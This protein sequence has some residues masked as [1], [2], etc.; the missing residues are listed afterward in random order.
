M[1]NAL[2]NIATDV[3]A[4]ATPVS[5]ANRSFT[6]ILAN[7][8][9]QKHGIYQ[10]VLVVNQGFS[11]CLQQRKLAFHQGKKRIFCSASKSCLI[12]IKDFL[13]HVMIPAEVC[14]EGIKQKFSVQN[15]S[16]SRLFCIA[17][18][19]NF[20]YCFDTSEYKPKKVEFIC[21]VFPDIFYSAKFSYCKNITYVN[22]I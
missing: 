10:L 21:L 22:Y 12:D 17:I 8:R 9:C 18:I 15:I 16:K 14:L 6:V 2:S 11:S 20:E 5:V 19:H 13:I 3:I 1:R 4:Y 7:V